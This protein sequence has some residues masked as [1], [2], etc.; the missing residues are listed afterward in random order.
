[1][2]FLQSKHLVQLLLLVTSFIIFNFVLVRWKELL[3]FDRFR[4]GTVVISAI[5]L[6]FILEYEDLIFNPFTITLFTLTVLLNVSH[7][8]LRLIF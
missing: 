7:F 8:V 5:S 3:A 6:V 1:M 4:Y 2:E